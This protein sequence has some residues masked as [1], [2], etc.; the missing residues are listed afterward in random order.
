MGQVRRS[1]L[2]PQNSHVFSRCRMRNAKFVYRKTGFT[3]VELLVVIAII[4]ILVGLILPAVQY[5]RETARR[6]QCQNNLKQLALA[7]H[8]AHDA[9]RY[10]PPMCGFYDGK[11]NPP[12]LNY[13]TGLAQDTVEPNALFHLLPFIEQ[14][15]LHD[16]ALDRDGRYRIMIDLLDGRPRAAST[17]VPTFV[18]PSDNTHSNGKVSTWG[19]SCFGVSFLVFGKPDAGD[20]V[21]K[22]ML[23][24]TRFA[25]LTDGLSNTI[26][27]GEKQAFCPLD[28]NSGVPWGQSAAYSW[29]MPMFLYGNQQGVGFRSVGFIDRARP[30]LVVGVVGAASKFQTTPGLPACKPALAQGN[31]P[32][33]MNAGFGDG[34]VSLLASSL[35]ASVWWQLCTPS[36]GEV[37]SSEF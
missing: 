14:Q 19:V 15:S 16:Y 34:H 26:F 13:N 5:A 9:H 1:S 35:D 36:A 28:V 7:S 33:G 23:G 22:N 21:N 2:S 20:D 6:M 3:L 30:G 17:S 29:Q 10:L 8:N 31:H 4:G 27:W 25:G 12:W 11:P 37:I 32:A 18:C 24:R